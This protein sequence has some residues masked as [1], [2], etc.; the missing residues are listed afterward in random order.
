MIADNFHI[1]LK[2]QGSVKI[3]VNMVVAYGLFPEHKNGTPSAL[4][5]EVTMI[6]LKKE[7]G[8]V[9]VDQKIKLGK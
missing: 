3:F 4:Q 5:T 1:L 6:F 2:V 7:R 8:C 9:T